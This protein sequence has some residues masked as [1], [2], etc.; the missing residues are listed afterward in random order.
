MNIQEEKVQQLKEEE[1]KKKEV[2]EWMDVNSN[3]F[4]GLN[5]GEFV[6]TESTAKIPVQSIEKSD[7]AQL[8]N[9]LHDR[10]D[11]L[12]KKRNAPRANAAEKM[13]SGE[14]TPRETQAWHL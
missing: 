2:A 5:N 12:R 13:H 3:A 6:V 7:I 10:I 11:Q 9:R 1:E 14:V 8:R 4:S